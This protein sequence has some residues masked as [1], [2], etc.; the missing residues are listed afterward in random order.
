MKPKLE[1]FVEVNIERSSDRK[2]F[3]F[4]L[5]FVCGH[6]HFNELGI[7]DPKKGYIVYILKQN[8]C[9]FFDKEQ[10]PK[11]L[12]AEVILIPN[13]VSY[14]EILKKFIEFAIECKNSRCDSI[15]SYISTDV[16]IGAGSHLF[17]K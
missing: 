11:L 6:T 9:K 1:D 12:R 13:E 8:E 5:T 16:G 17:N 14:L 3:D 7:T 10:F 15:T 4:P 2:E